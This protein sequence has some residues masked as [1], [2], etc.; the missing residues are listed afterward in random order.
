MQRTISVSGRADPATVWA[1][2]RS[3]AQWPEWAPQIRAV[4]PPEAALRPGLRGMVSGPLGLRVPFVVDAVDDDHRTWTWTVRV[5]AIAVRM[6]HDVRAT[7]TGSRTSLTVTGPWPVCAT[8][9]AV[10]RCALR[11]LVAPGPPAELTR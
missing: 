3:T 1:R 5:S 4:D 8:Y 6:Q 2:Y 7:S 11:R 9:P 10:A